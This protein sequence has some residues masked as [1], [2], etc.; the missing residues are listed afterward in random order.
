MDIVQLV[1]APLEKTSSRALWRMIRRPLLGVERAA[2]GAERR[3]GQ[4]CYIN[5]FG[6]DNNFANISTVVQF[7]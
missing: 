3:F 4:S 2:P 7:Y 6:A 5:G 1:E